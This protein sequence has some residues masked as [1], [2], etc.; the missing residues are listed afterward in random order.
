MKIAYYPAGPRT[1]ASSRM[2]VYRIADALQ[3][4]GHE[5]TIN[6]NPFTAD[7]IMVQK[8]FDL[9]RTMIECRQ[10]GIRV[11][12]DCDDYI[13]NGPAELAD[14]VTV[15]TPAKQAL[16]PGAAVI[17][18]ALDLDPGAPCKVEHSDRLRRVVWFGSADNAYHTKSVA[19]ACWRLNLELVIITDLGNAKHAAYW[20]DVHGVQWS[21]DTV[22]H[23]I[24]QADLVACAYVTGGDW[25]ADWVRS[26]S[27]NRL[28]KAWGLGMPTVGS[29]IPSYLQAG[30]RWQ[31]NTVGE[32]TIALLA[33]G[34]RPL[35]EADGAR[36]LQI[37]ARYQAERLAP[38]WLEVFSEPVVTR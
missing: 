28:I 4:L 9:Y 32:W 25:S 22:D 26:K 5:V 19:T 1:F 12:W 16:Y 36:G 10:K 30:L 31:A 14:L 7:V 3:A 35:R 11:I 2:R 24:I 33:L 29:S 38:R 13:P 37:A 8:R 21:L 18:D 20:Q 34:D 17:P 6:G 23:D 27:E 15:D